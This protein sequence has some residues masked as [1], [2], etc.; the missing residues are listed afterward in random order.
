MLNLP[1]SFY[2]A[3]VFVFCAWF[4]K[5]YYPEENVEFW[6]DIAMATSLLIPILIGS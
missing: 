6:V 1:V 5:K 2:L 4:N 3:L